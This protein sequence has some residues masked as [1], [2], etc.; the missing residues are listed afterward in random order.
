MC[1]SPAWVGSKT[2]FPGQMPIE[3]SKVNWTI[4]LLMYDHLFLTIPK[5]RNQRTIKLVNNAYIYNH[6][7]PRC[8]LH[9]SNKTLK[10]LFRT[11]PKYGYETF[12]LIKRS[13]EI[14]DKSERRILRNSFGSIHINDK[15]RIRK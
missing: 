3:K 2:R 4:D 12:T 7:R 14:I 1:I 11:V 15:F 9:K 10:T 6:E 8:S 13:E 5:I